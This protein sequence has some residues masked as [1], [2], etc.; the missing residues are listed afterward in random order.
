MTDKLVALRFPF[1]KEFWAVVV[2]GGMKANE[3]KEK[4]FLSKE[5]N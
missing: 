1:E 4:P 2:C 5:S 3:L